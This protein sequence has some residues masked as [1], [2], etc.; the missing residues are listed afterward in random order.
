D[1]GGPG[2]AVAAPAEAVGVVDVEQPVHA[3]DVTG[4][5]RGLQLVRDRVAAH[6][7]ARV[8]RRRVVADAV[9][10]GRVRG[11]AGRVVERVGRL[12]GRGRDDVRLH[13][14]PGVVERRPVAGDL[15]VD[16]LQPQ[17]VAVSLGR[18]LVPV[19]GRLDQERLHRVVRHALGREVAVGGVV[20][21]VVELGEALDVLVVAAGPVVVH[22]GGG[23][24]DRAVA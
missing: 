19:V 22:L 21:V 16:R 3:V 8:D 18:G 5:V 4:A 23:H 12:V 17:V 20:Q 2:G 11:R 1:V 7:H 6:A 13:G 15:P 9:V 14:G 10:L 24:L